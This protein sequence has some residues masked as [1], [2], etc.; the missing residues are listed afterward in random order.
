VAREDGVQNKQKWDHLRIKFDVL[1]HWHKK[2]GYNLPT[3]ALAVYLAL[4]R[5]ADDTTH[6]CYPSIQT[7]ADMSGINRDTASTAI[8]SL[9]RAGLI[10]IEPR[11]NRN[12]KTSH[13]YTILD[14][15]KPLPNDSAQSPVEMPD[16]SLSDTEESAM[17]LN[18]VNKSVS[19]ETPMAVAEKSKSPKTKPTRTYDHSRIVADPLFVRFWNVYPRH[20][21]K[22]DATRAWFKINPDDKLVATMIDALHWQ[23]LQPGW[24]KEG[25]QFV[26]YPATWLNGAQWEDERPQAPTGNGHSDTALDPKARAMARGATYDAF[27]VLVMPDG[28]DLNDDGSVAYGTDDF[29]EIA[30]K[31]GAKQHNHEPIPLVRPNMRNTPTSSGNGRVD[32][33]SGP[34]RTKGT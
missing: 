5:H 17:N 12:G 18:Q 23:K 21:R 3:S 7:L 10:G 2:A 14:V 24:V 27:G 11:V 31:R 9:E 20:I 30:R 25:G 34:Q 19:N 22:Q 15:G 29:A 1:D 8:R 16:F 4:A 33:H 28:T 32:A 13:L 6:D 26:P